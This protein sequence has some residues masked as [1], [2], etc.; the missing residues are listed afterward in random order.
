[1]LVDV[2]ADYRLDYTALV[3]VKVAAVDKMVGQRLAFYASPA[4]KGD[5]ELNLVD[6]A[7]L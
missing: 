2:Q 7:V 3:G 5:D 4:L 6:Q 1:V